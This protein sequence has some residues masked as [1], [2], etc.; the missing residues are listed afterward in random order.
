LHVCSVYTKQELRRIVTLVEERMAGRSVA[1][2]AF[3]VELRA[4]GIVQFRRMGMGPQGGPVGRNIVSHKLTED[5]P[6]S[7]SVPQRIGRVINI[8]T[9]ADTACSTKRVQEFLI[10]LK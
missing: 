3:K 9:I 7:G 1:V 6:A 8:S 4:A 5:R 10:G 2:Q